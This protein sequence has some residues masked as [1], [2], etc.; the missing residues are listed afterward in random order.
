MRCP[1]FEV[2]PEGYGADTIIP[3]LGKRMLEDKVPFSVR[4]MQWVSG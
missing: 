3:I 2:T 4:I 1:K